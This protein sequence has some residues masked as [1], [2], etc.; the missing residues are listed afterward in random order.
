MTASLALTVDV[1][2]FY[3]GMAVLG[4]PLERPADA[5]SGLEGLLARLECR[6]DARLTCFVV[7]D[8]AKAVHEPLAELARRGHEIASHGPDHGRLPGR[9]DLAAW[10]RRGREMVEDVVQVPVTG[11]RSPRFDVPEAGLAFYRAQLAEA[12]YRYVSDTS[13]L[14][15]GSP[16]AELPVLGAGSHHLGGGSYQRF[17][18]AAVSARAVASAGG[19]AVCYYHSYD[20]GATLP[21]L[22]SA[23]S[24][25][26]VRQLVARRRVAV[27]FDALLERFG[28]V[29]CVDAIG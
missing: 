23:R 9:G 2:D 18:P 21:P 29:C 27:V 28:S 7:G 4:C 11:F 3:D 25:A 19:P 8:Y 10:L 14:G 17:L 16:V 1:E 22:S 12:G 5:R 20:F 6:P 26:L 15:P 13:R 24:L